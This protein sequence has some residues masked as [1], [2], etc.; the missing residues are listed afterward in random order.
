MTTSTGEPLPN[1]A[2][3]LDSD[4]LWVPPARGQVRPDDGQPD[5]VGALTLRALATLCQAIELDLLAAAEGAVLDDVRTLLVGRAQSCSARNHDLLLALPAAYRV[6]ARPPALSHAVYPGD[7]DRVRACGQAESLA[8]RCYEAA[9]AKPLPA[10]WQALLVRQ[11]PDVRLD[12]DLLEAL[13]HRLDRP[14]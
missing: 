6:A 12:P 13:Q 3:V 2:H 4:G 10:A 9:L 5:D 14:T 11:L 7:A 8:L 1:G